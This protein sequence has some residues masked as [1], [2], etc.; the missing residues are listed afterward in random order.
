LNMFQELQI[1]AFVC[2]YSDSGCLLFLLLLLLLLPWKMLDN[3]L[4]N[5]FRP[6][7]EGKRERYFSAWPDLCIRF[8][9]RLKHWRC[10]C[11][12]YVATRRLLDVHKS[13]HPEDWCSKFPPQTMVNSY[14]AIRHYIPKHSNI[15]SYHH[16][17]LTSRPKSAV[18]NLFRLRVPHLT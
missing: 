4:L 13:F 6:R 10:L 14:Q 16:E 5:F 11:L 17:N 9:H 1:F 3:S 12:P 8:R 18:P 7:R 2:I 15:H